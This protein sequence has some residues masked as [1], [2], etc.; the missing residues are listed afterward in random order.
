M[1]VLAE[2]GRSRLAHRGQLVVIRNNPDNRYEPRLEPIAS[3]GDPAEL[4]KS[5]RRNAWNDYTVFVQGNHYIH[6][7]NGRVMAM[8][9]DEDEKSFRRSGFIGFQLPA[10]PPVRVEIREVRLRALR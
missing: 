8:A 2:E 10:G 5:I 3:V 7:I 4:E 9:I 1:V 6:I